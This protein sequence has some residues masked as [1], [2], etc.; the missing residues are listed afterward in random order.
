MSVGQGGTDKDFSRVA[1]G[2]RAAHEK[3]FLPRVGYTLVGFAEQ[4]QGI[5]APERRVGFGYVYRSGYG[6]A[7]A[8]HVVGDMY[9]EAAACGKCTAGIA[10]A[11]LIRKSVAAFAFNILA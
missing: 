3:Q 8:G 5:G 1:G 4:A 6:V 7:S 10:R 2:I 9:A 11:A